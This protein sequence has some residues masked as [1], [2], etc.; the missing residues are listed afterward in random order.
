MRPA[1]GR[2]LAT[3]GAFLLLLMGV[4]GAAA[5]PQ[6]HAL[7]DPTLAATAAKRQQLLY[8][9]RCALPPEVV[10]YADLEDER[11]TFPGAIGLAP[12]WL[13]EPMTPSEERWVSACLLAHVNYFGKHVRISIRATGVSVPELQASVDEQQTYTIFEG[14]FFG[15]LFAP[16]PVAYTC[17]GARTPTHAAD[18]MLRDRV[19]TEETEVTTTEG[20]PV[21]RCQ[22]LLAGRC[23]DSTSFTIGDTA[24][25]EV[26]F[27][28]LK[29]HQP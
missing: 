9:V 18:P 3:G 13:T 21:T 19:C 26:I 25:A 12:H 27:V 8:L 17:Q 6:L 15:N 28:Y 2:L 29:P 5:A 1:L 24:Y 16:T 7:A 10:L 14:G 20:I 22:F 4:L 11:F 23:E